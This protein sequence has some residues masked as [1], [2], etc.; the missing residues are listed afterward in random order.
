[1]LG[2]WIFLSVFWVCETWMYL[3]GHNTFLF[4]H[5]T[6]SEKADRDRQTGNQEAR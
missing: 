2:F 6:D 1:M 3:R 4:T 5:K